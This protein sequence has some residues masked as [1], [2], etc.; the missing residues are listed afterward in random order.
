MKNLVVLD[1]GSNSVRLSINKIKNDSDHRFTEVKRLKETTRLAEGMGNIGQKKLS[2]GA[3]KR[4]IQAIKYFKRIYQTY[5]DY[6]VLS[7]ATAAVREASNSQEFIDEV[8]ALTGSRIRV[9]S[10]SDEAYYDYLGVV[11]TLPIRDFLL[12]DMGGGSVEIAIVSERELVRS[13]SL[14]YGAVSLSEQFC[15]NGSLTEENLESFKQFSSKLFDG[16]R[17]LNEAKGLP[18]V[19]L[20]GCNRTVARI[21]RAQE[22]FFN[23][24]AI[25]GYELKIA[26]FKKIYYDLLEFSTKERLNIKGM[27]GSRADIILGGMTPLDVLI[28][29]LNSKKII[30]SESG[31]REGLLYEMVSKNK[32]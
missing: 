17:W 26:D 14:P 32:I 8:L 20:G 5:P 10:G 3:I 27:E 16:L 1:F 6:Q 13:V 25:H 15:Q 24:D 2:A 4:T 23:L 9:L 19:L 12:V 30:F 22:G 11:S 18:V 28:E 29:R 7:I 21:K 31:V